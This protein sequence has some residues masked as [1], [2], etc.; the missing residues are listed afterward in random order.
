M[1]ESLVLTNFVFIMFTK[2]L[3][4]LNCFDVIFSFIL[5]SCLVLFF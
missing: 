3:K 1:F 5:F 2:Y 4:L